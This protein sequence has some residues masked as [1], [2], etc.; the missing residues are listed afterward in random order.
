LI[1]FYYYKMG[2]SNTKFP[3]ASEVYMIVMVINSELMKSAKPHPHY[4]DMH[5]IIMVDYNGNILKMDPFINTETMTGRIMSEYLG[6]YLMVKIRGEM[7]HFK[8]SEDVKISE[9]NIKYY[10]TE[11]NAFEDFMKEKKRNNCLAFNVAMGLIETTDT[12]INTYSTYPP[13]YNPGMGRE[14]PLSTN[15]QVC[16][17]PSTRYWYKS[18]PE[19]SSDFVIRSPPVSPLSPVAVIS[20][21]D[22]EQG[23]NVREFDDDISSIIESYM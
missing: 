1:I 2:N 16:C 15:L 21:S 23:D 13:K 6:V 7:Y 5:Q 11:R 22:I 19:P 17:A 18:S 9:D 12:H 4:D 10:K 8:I 20:K 14:Y 3:T